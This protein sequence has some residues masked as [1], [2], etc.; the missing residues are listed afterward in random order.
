MN[1]SL[2]SNDGT[3]K[4]DDNSSLELQ[5]KGLEIREKELA[6]R[7]QEIDYNYKYAR[8]SLEAQERDR[9]DQR[10]HEDKEQRRNNISATVLITFIAALIGMAIH[11]DQ[12]DWV[13]EVFRLLIVAAGGYWWGFGRGKRRDD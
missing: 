6:T 11:Y 5:A 12:A 3:S 4:N 1:D 7:S 10:L 13:T 8:A 2:G 9:K